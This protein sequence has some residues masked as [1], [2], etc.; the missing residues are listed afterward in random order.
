MRICLTT[1]ADTAFE[2]MRSLCAKTLQKYSETQNL[3][4]LL[5]SPK[6]IIKHYA[7]TS[8]QQREKNMTLDLM[9][10]GLT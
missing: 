4:I 7:G 2:H 1:C 9:R 10:I 8:H 5:D 6:P 3:D